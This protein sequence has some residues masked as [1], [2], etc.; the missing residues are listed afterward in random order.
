MI[1]AAGHLPASFAAH[2]P[3]ERPVVLGI[4]DQSGF[5]FPQDYVDFL[6]AMN[7]GAGFVGG[8]LYA[9]IW[10]AEDLIHRNEEYQVSNFAPGI[11]LFGTDGGGEGFGFDFRQE[12]FRVVQIPLIGM[13]LDVAWV[14][15]DSFTDFISGRV[16]Q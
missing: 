5:K 6:C 15:A 9:N 7:G 16:K 8:D 12:P 11:F 1:D 14:I 10:R 13:S 4:R 2:P 3:A